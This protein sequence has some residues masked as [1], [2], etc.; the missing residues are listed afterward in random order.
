MRDIDSIKEAEHIQ[1]AQRGDEDAYFYLVEVYQK[2]VYNLCFRMLGDGFEAEDAAQ[3]AFMRAYRHIKRYDNERK[4]STWLLSIASNYCIDLIRKR[5]FYQVPLDEAET[6]PEDA[7]ETPEPE[8]RAILNEE[9][10]AV[11]RLL[12]TLQ[13]ADRAVVVL[14]YWYDCSYEEIASILS[15]SIPAV[16]SRMHRSKRSLALALADQQW[17]PIHGARCD[18]PSVV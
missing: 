3:E 14:F 10:S 8:A 16:K 15:L 2:P 12:R 1:R 9:Q 18:E 17:I 4:F 7:Y 6:S 11:Q 13:P 5:K